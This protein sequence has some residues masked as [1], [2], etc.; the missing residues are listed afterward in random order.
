MEDLKNPPSLSPSYGVAK[1]DYY[2]YLDS[3]IVVGF[4]WAVGCRR[5]D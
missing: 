5:S 2:D 3:I 4:V 1:E